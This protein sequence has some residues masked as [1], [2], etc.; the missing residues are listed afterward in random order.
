VTARFIPHDN[1]GFSL[2]EVM[3]AAGLVVCLAAGSARLFAVTTRA[4]AAA[5]TRTATALLAA[6]KIAEI[7]SSLASSNGVEPAA[8]GSLDTSASPFVDYTDASGSP[9]TGGGTP[10]RAAVFV[11]RWSVQPLPSNPARLLVLQVVVFRVGTRTGRGPV[12]GAIADDCRL[13]TLY[14]IGS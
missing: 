5:G 10:P 6:Q 9:V 2:V 14:R 12:R 3:I 4:T 1:Q 8:G 7:Q 13:A 11:R